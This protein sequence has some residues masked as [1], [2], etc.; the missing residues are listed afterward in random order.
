MTMGR[1]TQIMSRIHRDDLVRLALFA[2][3]RADLAGAIDAIAP[4][5]VAHGTY[6]AELGRTPH[7]PVPLP[8]A[9]TRGRAPRKAQVSS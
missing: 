6:R 3:D 7:R 9:W 4:Y 5:P 1:G 2:L 8:A